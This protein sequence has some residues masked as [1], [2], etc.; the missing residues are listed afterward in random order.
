MHGNV[1]QWCDDLYDPAGSTRVYRGGDW[2]NPAVYCRAAYRNR[3]A[4]D[5]RVNFLGF[6][7]ARD[8]IR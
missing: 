3:L 4:P 6:R 8:P 2:G 1:E 7:L 5:V